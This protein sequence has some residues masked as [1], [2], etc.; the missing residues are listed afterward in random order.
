MT[1]ERRSLAGTH[2]ARAK[3][4]GLGYSDTGKEQIAVLFQIADGPHNGKHIHWYGYFTDET[5]DQTLMSMRHCG[6][7]SESLAELDTLGDNDVMLVIEDEEYQGKWRSR[8]R[9]VNRVPKLALKSQ[10]NMQQASD[11][12]QKLRGKTVASKQKYGAQPAPT[13]SNGRRREQQSFDDGQARRE[14]GL[15]EDDSIPF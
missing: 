13:A 4:W 6:W 2:R 8:V 15:A 14:A 11:F 9:W 10:M 7:A 12:A 1:Q 3:E 5:L